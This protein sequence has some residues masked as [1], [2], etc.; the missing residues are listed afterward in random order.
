MSTPRIAARRLALLLFFPACHT[1]RPVALA[2][3]TGFETAGR[4]RVERKAPSTDSLVVSANGSAGMSHAP[5]V[6]H[7][8]SV[9]GDSLFGFRSGSTQPIA[10][11][12]ADV[13]RAEERRFSGWR[14]TLL[15]IG[16]VVGGFVGLVGLVLASPGAAGL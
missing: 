1:W 13:V 11:A 9:D 7:G 10:I 4:V 5:V 8:V 12:V 6:F 14:T 3:N 16:V 2:P 15:G